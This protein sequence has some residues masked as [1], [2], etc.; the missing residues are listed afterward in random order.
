[1]IS[2]VLHCLG[3][4][5]KPLMTNKTP[6]SPFLGLLVGTASFVIVVAGM[7]AAA[8]IFN[9][10]FLALLIAICV[11]PLL[12]WLL[13]KRLSGGLALLVTILTVLLAGTILIAFLGISLSELIKIVPTYEA[14]IDDLTA[15]LGRFL[16]GKGIK[17][18]PVFSLDLLQPRQLIKTT[19]L[20]LK[21]IGNTLG[22]SLLLLLIVAFMLV[23]STGF[24]TKLQ[25]VLKPN[26]RVL[27]QLKH[28]TTDIRTYMAIT[29]GAGTIAAF[30]DFVVL[31]LLGVDLAPLWGVM[32]F[33]LSFIPGV[34]FLLA[35]I[36]PFLLALLE[37]DL[38]RALLVFVGCFLVDNVVDKG[39]KPKFMQE[40]L[41]LSIL[42]IFLSVVF[43][44]W[45]LGPTGALLSVPLTMMVKKIV[46]E[47]FEETRS[48]AI[49]LGTGRQDEPAPNS[50]DNQ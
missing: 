6:F 48:L 11:T 47:S 9:A 23:E 49:L 17:S 2:T 16:H 38:T 46:L 31:L 30:G 42:T 32:F 35:V 12:Q 39:I 28:F 45:V 34:G 21:T 41:D 20:F 25:Q 27:G 40:G 43:W 4:F 22:A 33:L 24:P 36:P 19:I 44:S 3:Y 37:F 13:R 18:E 7:Q 14:R 29:A 1:M 15:S 10:F 50:L 26:S 5:K 8:S